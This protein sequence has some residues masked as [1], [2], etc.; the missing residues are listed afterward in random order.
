MW[1]YLNIQFTAGPISLS[2]LFLFV[3][4][5]HKQARTNTCRHTGRAR[6]RNM[7]DT[8]RQSH[9]LCVLFSACVWT[10]RSWRSLLLTLRSI[11]SCDCLQRKTEIN[12][13]KKNRKKQFKI[14]VIVCAREH[15][16]DVALVNFFFSLF[17]FSNNEKW[18]QY[19]FCR[20]NFEPFKSMK[21]CQ[22]QCQKWII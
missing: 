12:A 3:W 7:S 8:Q 2:L 6:D 21:F 13:T 5:V 19:A 17:F 22:T 1:K 18:Q 16:D 9:A 10:R 15:D 4:F 20:N 11:R 14:M